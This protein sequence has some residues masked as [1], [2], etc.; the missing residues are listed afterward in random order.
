MFRTN[1]TVEFNMGFAVAAFLFPHENWMKSRGHLRAASM[2]AGVAVAAVCWATR[3]VRVHAALCALLSCYTVFHCGR[4]FKRQP[5][6]GI[7][8]TDQ[9]E[10]GKRAE[11]SS[12][13][14]VEVAGQPARKSIL[15]KPLVVN[16]NMED[17]KSD[18]V[19]MFTFLGDA[20]TG[21]PKMRSLR[22]NT[23][24]NQGSLTVPLKDAPSITINGKPAPLPMPAQF[25]GDFQSTES[26]SAVPHNMETLLQMEVEQLKRL[27][28]HREEEMR[29]MKELALVREQMKLNFFDPSEGASCRSTGSEQLVDQFA[30]E[31]PGFDAVLLDGAYS[32]EPDAVC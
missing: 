32:P 1:T 5:M 29:M 25:K 19:G 23:S 27:I 14:A 11:E 16:P 26:I 6:A 17:R 8:F 22:M 21:D 2:Y 18:Y 4:Y 3:D 9:K 12:G 13:G 7:D 15:R 28:L 10:N 24:V 30:T 20:R 31:T